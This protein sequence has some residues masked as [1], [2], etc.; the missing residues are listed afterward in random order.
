M[1][2]EESSGKLKISLLEAS[3]VDMFKQ[4]LGELKRGW[5]LRDAD[6][7]RICNLY[8]Q[9]SCWRGSHLAARR[10]PERTESSGKQSVPG[11]GCHGDIGQLPS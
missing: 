1:F 7:E 8:F 11:I 2:E 9:G 10:Q 6:M 3:N 5:C 4:T